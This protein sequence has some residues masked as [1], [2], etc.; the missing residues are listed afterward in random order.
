MPQRSCR[1]QRYRIM[2]TH[3]AM[4]FAM[5][6]TMAATPAAAFSLPLAARAVLVRHGALRSNQGIS[7]GVGSEGMRPGH[8][9]VP[10]ESVCFRTDG[11]GRAGLPLRGGAGRSGGLGCISMEVQGSGEL[12]TPR[13]LTQVSERSLLVPSSLQSA[14]RFPTLP[15]SG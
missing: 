11:R 13:T 2:A 12:E 15:L 14:F 8:K 9:L 4:A 3:L 7:S 5:F 10:R 6:G 1:M